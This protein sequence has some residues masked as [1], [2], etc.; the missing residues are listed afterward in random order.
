M[1]EAPDREALLVDWLREL[2]YIQMSEGLL[3]TAV[4]IGEL[5]E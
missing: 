5:A 4:E 3:V 2:L 1:L